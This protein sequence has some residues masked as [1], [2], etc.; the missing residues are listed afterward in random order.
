[1][2]IQGRGRDENYKTACLLEP[3]KQHSDHSYKTI[4]GIYYRLFEKIGKKGLNHLIDLVAENRIED[5]YDPVD[6][7]KDLGWNIVR[8]Y[9]E[10]LHKDFGKEYDRMDPVQRVD[11]IPDSLTVFTDGCFEGGRDRLND[12]HIVGKQVVK[13]V[14]GRSGKLAISDRGNIRKRKMLDSGSIE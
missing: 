3:H 9:S 6:Y 10:I 5:A 7:L 4:Q 11:G 2:L 14:E 13:R 1:M 12:P 8:L